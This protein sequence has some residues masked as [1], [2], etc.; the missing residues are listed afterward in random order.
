MP[1]CIQNTPSTSFS[2][3]EADAFKHA[4]HFKG[5]VGPARLGGI[6]CSSVKVGHL[7]RKGFSFKKTSN[8]SV[9]VQLGQKVLAKRCDRTS[10]II[11]DSLNG[12]WGG[13]VL[14]LS[15]SSQQLLH[16]YA[17]KNGDWTLIPSC[18]WV[19]QHANSFRIIKGEA[20]RKTAAELTETLKAHQPNVLANPCGVRVGLVEWLGS[21]DLEI[22]C[23]ASEAAQLIQMPQESLVPPSEHNAHTPAS[24]PWPGGVVPAQVGLLDR[25]MREVFQS[26]SEGYRV[27]TFYGK[28]P[29]APKGAQPQHTIAIWPGNL[30]K[31]SPISLFDP[32]FGEF[33]FIDQ[34]KFIEWFEWL[35]SQLAG[36]EKRY[37]AFDISVVRQASNPSKARSLSERLFGTLRSV[38]GE[39]SL[40]LSDVS[41]H[42]L[43]YSSGGDWGFGPCGFWVA[44]H[45]ESG[46]IDSSSRETGAAW[47]NAFKANLWGVGGGKVSLGALLE[48]HGLEKK[49]APQKPILSG[50]S[51]LEEVFNSDIDEYKLFTLHGR[52]SPGPGGAIRTHTIATWWEIKGEG[53][54]ICLFD[55]A[56]GEIQFTDRKQFSNWFKQQF[57]PISG[58]QD[59]Y[60]RGRMTVRRIHTSDAY[61]YELPRRD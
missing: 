30:K 51:L 18:F 9:N 35:F 5:S 44:H 14:E 58:Y 6:L 1:S 12:T 42:L 40:D 59:S 29:Q 15:G 43:K 27:I 23:S 50:Y 56:H 45:F 39:V 28:A 19:A 53:S 57:W 32:A 61:N 31:N 21:R 48:K 60:K 47:V 55:P 52:A 54:L 7:V 2:T 33:Q 10:E 38:G 25:M 36:Y 11:S 13:R 41:H 3:S 34:R 46:R 16:G 22:D 24:A 49:R 20:A 8:S 26:D 4:A 17:Q 37:N